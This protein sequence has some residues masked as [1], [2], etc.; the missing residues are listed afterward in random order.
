MDSATMSTVS[1][2][3]RS[4]FSS[5]NLV[6]F[7]NRSSHNGIS[8]PWPIGCTNRSWARSRK[9]FEVRTKNA[10]N[11]CVHEPVRFA[12][13]E[14]D[15]AIL[16]KLSEPM[17]VRLFPTI[18]LE[19]QFLDLLSTLKQRHAVE[20][21]SKKTLATSSSATNGRTAA[22]QIA[23][24]VIASSS[25]DHGN[26]HSSNSN[27]P[28]ATNGHHPPKVTYSERSQVPKGPPLK[29]FK[30]DPKF[31]PGQALRYDSPVEVHFADGSSCSAQ[32][33]G[34]LSGEGNENDTKHTFPHVYKLPQFTETLRLALASK[35]A[36]AFKLRTYYRNLLISSIY[37]D[38][39]RTYNLW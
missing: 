39:T 15:G 25:F 21:N 11:S 35:D 22:H 18:K 14:I 36:S 1:S 3:L 33:N 2:A 4:P 8:T 5:P 30:R 38:L 12:E 6:E 31:F 19:V 32:S 7:R 29:A 26:G 34:N 37:D 17:V 24:H 13:N 27:S 23:A 16:L 9:S 28:I 10:V 20:S